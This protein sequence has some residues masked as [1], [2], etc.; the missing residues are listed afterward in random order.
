L[1]TDCPEDLGDTGEPTVFDD[2][3]SLVGVTY[4]DTR[5]DFVDGACFKILRDWA[6][7][8]WC[9]YNSLTGAG[10]W[11]YIQVI[12]VHDNQG[13][14]FTDC[15]TGPVTLCVADEG[16]SLPDNNQAFLGEENPAASSCSVHLNLHRHVHETCS[17]IV[18]YDVKFYPFNGDEFIYLKTT[19]TV[20]VDENNDADLSFDTRQNPTQAIRLNGYSLQQ[21]ILR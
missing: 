14:I 7:I 9:Q 15:P 3:C 20:P 19:T 1:L 2:A 6:I 8:D 10:L 4:E 17:D 18:N 5:F 21:P 16:V 12:K 13:P 11:H